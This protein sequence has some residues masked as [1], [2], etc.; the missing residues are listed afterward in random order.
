VNNTVTVNEMI[1][2]VN[3]LLKDEYDAIEKRQI[4]YVDLD[5]QDET[6]AIYKELEA[7][8][9]QGGGENDVTADTRGKVNGLA[10]R[11]YEAIENSGE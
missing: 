10:A 8:S 7:E 1:R 2:S 11:L 6:M 9:A 4:Q 3:K 5:W